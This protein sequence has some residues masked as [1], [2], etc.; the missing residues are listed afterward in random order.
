VDD[1][2]KVLVGTVLL[3]RHPIEIELS[4]RDAVLEPVVA[5][6]ECL[7]SLHADGGMLVSM[8]VVCG[9]FLQVLC[10]WECCLAR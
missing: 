1:A 4:L 3:A 9:P 2:L 5:H 6:V 8:G 10:E 7:G